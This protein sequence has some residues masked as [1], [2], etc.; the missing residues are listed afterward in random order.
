MSDARD[1]RTD[2]PQ[3]G[4]SLMSWRNER[5]RDAIVHTFTEEQA[6][7]WQQNPTFRVMVENAIAMIPLTIKGI[8]S[9]AERMQAEI[10]DRVRAAQTTT[11][12]VFPLEDI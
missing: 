3:K 5:I 4:G 10:M 11:I 7:M 2:G 6:R 9:E 8:E 12:P 1:E